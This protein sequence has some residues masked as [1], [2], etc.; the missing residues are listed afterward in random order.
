M[1]V[2]LPDGEFFDPYNGRAAVSQRRL[3]T[4]IDAK[5]SFADDP[6]R[7]LRAARF[8]PRFDLEPAS[9]LSEA[10]TLLADRL[11]VVSQERISAELDRLLEVEDPRAGFD[12]LLQVDALRYVIP[13]LSL[14]SQSERNIATG[15]ASGPGSVSVRRAGLVYP[16]FVAG[17][18]AAVRQALQ[19]LR[20][21]GDVQTKTQRL[22]ESL[23][24]AT[25]NDASER[26][27]RS[28][29]ATAGLRVS[30]SESGAGE[31][32]ETTGLVGDL[33][34][35]AANVAALVGPMTFDGSI[36]AQMRQMTAQGRALVLPQPLTGHEIIKILG[37]S[38]GPKIGAVK[39]YLRKQWI[40]T[41]DFSRDQAVILV[42]QWGRDNT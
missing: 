8:L 20:Y 5:E 30:S 29:V 21:S 2:S 37:G 39:A 23:T 26:D 36:F 16:V 32:Q 33:E 7:M 22:L 24:A 4:P 42:E 34:V 1:A 12:F 25:T 11:G 41:G 10:A 28:F 13:A 40:N 15:L 6:L 35:L 38:E 31:L 14:V 19:E 17:G 3:E 18:S 9:G 27:V